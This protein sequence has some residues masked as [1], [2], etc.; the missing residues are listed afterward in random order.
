M[1]DSLAAAGFRVGVQVDS[2]IRPEGMHNEG[3]WRREF[4]RA[5]RWLFADTAPRRAP[6]PRRRAH[7][8]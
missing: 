3:F 6:R 8:H 2:V 5:Y 1:I 4:A 7:G